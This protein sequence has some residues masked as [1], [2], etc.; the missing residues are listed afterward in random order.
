MIGLSKTVF[1]CL[2]DYQLRNISNKLNNIFYDSDGVSYHANKVNLVS[3]PLAS[4]FIYNDIVVLTENEL[5][6]LILIKNIILSLD[7]E[8]VLMI[9]LNLVLVIMLFIVLMV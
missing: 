8:Q 2:K 9:Y 3:I 6:K 1:I 7:M 5:F 4:G